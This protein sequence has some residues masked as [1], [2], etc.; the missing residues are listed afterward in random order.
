MSMFQCSRSKFGH[1][2]PPGKLGGRRE[3]GRGHHSSTSRK[4][5]VA[6]CPSRVTYNRLGEL[7]QDT[8]PGEIA[9]TYKL[10]CR[11]SLDPDPVKLQQ[12][13]QESDK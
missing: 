8:T 2:T 5:I 13:M 4:Q 11:V 12:H 3:R 1:N 9:H 10:W 7:I 6:A